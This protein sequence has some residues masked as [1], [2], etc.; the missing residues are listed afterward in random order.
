MS[1]A[2]TTNTPLKRRKRLLSTHRPSISSDEPRLPQK[3]KKR[4]LSK[5]SS[6]ANLQITTS[7]PNPS[8]PSPPPTA[9]TPSPTKRSIRASSEAIAKR[10]KERQTTRIKRKRKLNSQKVVLPPS[11]DLEDTGD[12]SYMD[13]LNSSSQLQ[14][15]QPQETPLKPAI[16]MGVPTKQNKI[17]LVS[18]PSPSP[19]PLQKKQQKKNTLDLS[20][21]SILPDSS[22]IAHLP[23]KSQKSSVND[24]METIDDNQSN[25]TLDDEES[26]PCS[27]SVFFD[28]INDFEDMSL[29]EDQR[30]KILGYE[31][32]Q[33]NED[34][35]QSSGGFWQMLFRPFS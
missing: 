1:F 29:S 32:D 24:D 34:T 16:V 4:Q 28:A 20:H 9:I 8:S 3:K 31:Q 6:D 2:N 23:N 33:S 18:S 22:Y 11:E 25:L 12:M 14:I 10:E 30:E 13:Y 17:R 5:P 26:N 21:H 15:S 19:R 35:Q 7:L 27:P